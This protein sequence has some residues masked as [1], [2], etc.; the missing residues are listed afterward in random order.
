MCRT[1]GADLEDIFASRGVFEPNLFL[2]IAEDGRS[3]VASRYSEM[4]Q[5]VL[6]ATATLMAEE[7]EVSLEQIEVVQAHKP[8]FGMQMTGGSMSTAGMFLPVR[9]AGA[10]AREMLRTAASVK[11]G[12]P[13]EECIAKD[14]QVHHTTTEQRLMYGELTSLAILQPVPSDPPLKS[15]SDFR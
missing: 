14:G 6:T 3:L 5:G 1:K 2:S 8:G 10:A 11:W 4:G 15:D 9:K 13:L 12:V 7:L